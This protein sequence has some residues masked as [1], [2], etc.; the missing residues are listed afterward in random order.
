MLANSSTFSSDM[1]KYLALMLGVIAALLITLAGYNAVVDPLW[2]F[3]YANRWNSNQ[4]GFD[5][6]Q[7]KTNRARFGSFD[8]DGIM[9]GSSRSTYIN[10]Y[11]FTAR[12]IFN[13]AVSGMVPAEYPAFVR[14]ATKVH[15]EPLAEVFIGLD[16]FSSSRNYNNGA[17]A[18][19]RYFS[20][21][22][23]PFYR[24]EMLISVDTLRK[25]RESVAN[26]ER[27]CDCYDRRNV[28]YLR[29]VSSNEHQE[30]LAKDLAHFRDRVYSN[31][32]YD[33]G[34]PKLWRSLRAE[35]PETRFTVFTTPISAA[36]FRELVRAGR[37]PDLERWL[38]DAVDTFGEVTDFMGVNSIT[39]ADS[40]YQDGSHFYPETGD[41]IA[42]RLSRTNKS[43]PNDFGIRVTAENLDAH[44]VQL[45]AQA[46]F[47]LS[48]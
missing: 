31:Y 15:G 29:R 36:L 47:L 5:E 4:V 39:I 6:R 42:R 32:I 46:R 11:E 23:K 45:R 12:R 34:L 2:F 20:T 28:K 22:E 18:P 21:V 27:N 44:L 16:F 37:L 33:E 35:N 17:S 3:T 8:Y 40:R 38:R 25:S 9:L 19:E 14:F 41:L 7:Q 24:A 43:V 48:H 26:G 30:L 1:G 10:Q 13:F